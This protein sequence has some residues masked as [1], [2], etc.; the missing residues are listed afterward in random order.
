[1]V[2]AAVAV[3]MMGAAAWAGGGP[4]ADSATSQFF[5]SLSSPLIHTCCDVADCAKAASDYRVDTDGV[6]AWWARSNRTGEWVRIEP[7]QITTQESIFPEAILCEGDPWTPSG[8]Q[9]GG[10]NVTHVLCFA[11]PPQLF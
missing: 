11:R 4:Y 2:T 9:P 5:Q 7:D 10:T 8:E 1:M 3:Q 6:G